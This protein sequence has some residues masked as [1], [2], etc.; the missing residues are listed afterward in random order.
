MDFGIYLDAQDWLIKM[1]TL[2][3]LTGHRYE[4]PLIFAGLSRFLYHDK[5][6]AFLP[7]RAANRRKRL[8]ND[9]DALNLE[10]SQVRSFLIKI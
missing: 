4:C 3:L 8:K 2:N 7:T 6:L 5:T 1:S 9:K 10:S